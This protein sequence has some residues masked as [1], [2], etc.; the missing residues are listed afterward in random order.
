MSRKRQRSK[1]P[2][3]G[4]FQPFWNAVSSEWAEKLP[5]CDS[6]CLQRTETLSQSSWYTKTEAQ[7]LSLSNTPLLSHAAISATIIKHEQEK[8]E[9]VTKK[10][11]PDDEEVTITRTR[12]I[13]VYPTTEQ[14]TKLNEWFGAVRFIYNRCVAEFPEAHKKVSRKQLRS[15]SISNKKINEEYPWLLKVPYDVRDS[16]ILD[17]FEAKKAGQAKNQK[18]TL[19]FRTRKRA[20]Q[21]TFRIR[22]RDWG[23][24]RGMYK[25]CFSRETLR[26]SEP[27]PATIDK[28]V[29]ITRTRPGE[30]YLTIPR[31]VKHIESE[32]Q[33]PTMVSMDPGVRTFQTTF[34][35]AGHV[36]EWGKGD[37]KRIYRLCTHVD[38]IV[39][40]MKKV[41]CRKRRRL[42]VGML[43]IRKRIRSLVK[44]LHCKLALWL[45][46]HYKVVLLPKFDTQQMVEKR[47]GKRKMA[48]KTA[49]IMYVEPL[50]L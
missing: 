43:R 5:P 37:F 8:L 36:T 13:R 23:R 21:E 45:C 6:I 47:E 1:T 14:K 30:Y 50:S 39:S 24:K 19:K 35:L 18:G 22:G 25:W 28:T 41:R 10:A 32:N 27:L 20:T 2:S 46:Q 29:E 17:V 40:S 12:K 4:D 38:T 11:R 42:R 7:A 31:E 26:S 3:N 34:D 16:A 48:S 15:C 9:R 44:E 33:A 49:R